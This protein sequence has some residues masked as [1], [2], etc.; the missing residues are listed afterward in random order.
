MNRKLTSHIKQVLVI[1]LISAL[2]LLTCILY[3]NRVIPKDFSAF[4]P[5]SNS[6]INVCIINSVDQEPLELHENNLKEFLSILKGTQYYYNGH[7][8]N[9]LVGNLYHV[10]FLEETNGQRSIVLS[11]IISDKDIVY[12]GDKQYDIRSE[13]ISVVDFL[14]DLY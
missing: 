9:I 14:H 6:I 3:F 7:Y 2:V 10:E 1:L 12:V 11:M 5:S 13:S 8:G 4:L